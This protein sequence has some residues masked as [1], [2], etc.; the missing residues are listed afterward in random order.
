[1]LGLIYMIIFHLI[2]VGV[3]VVLRSGWETYSTGCT[4]LGSQDLNDEEIK[5]IA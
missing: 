3:P 5:R 2:L 4:E 1:M